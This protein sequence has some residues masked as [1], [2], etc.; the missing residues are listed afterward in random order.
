[1]YCYGFY[2]VEFNDN[3]KFEEVVG[4]EDPCGVHNKNYEINEELP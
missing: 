2:V 4:E 3:D 1:L